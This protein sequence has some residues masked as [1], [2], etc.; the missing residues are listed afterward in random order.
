L[1]QAVGLEAG[2]GVG[3]A[4]ARA[5]EPAIK[6][7]VSVSRRAQRNGD[8]AH[9]G[10]KRKRFSCLREKLLGTPPSLAALPNLRVVTSD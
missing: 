5:A 6:A 7:V 3:W 4:K 8:G 2:G 1:K 10:T 9:G